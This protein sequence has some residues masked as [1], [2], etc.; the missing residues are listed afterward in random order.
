MHNSPKSVTMA[1]KQTRPWVTYPTK[2][3]KKFTKNF[4]G[5]S[6]KKAWLRTQK[7]TGGKINMDLWMTG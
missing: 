2:N 6:L 3:C 1:E 4:N 5:K 7:E